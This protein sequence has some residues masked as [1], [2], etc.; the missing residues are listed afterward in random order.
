MPWL[1]AEASH[2]GKQLPPGEL[3]VTLKLF[4]VIRYTL[5]S[6]TSEAQVAQLRKHI[7]SFRAILTKLHPFLPARVTNFHIIEHIPDDIPTYEDVPPGPTRSQSTQG[8]R[9]LLEILRHHHSSVYVWGGH[10]AI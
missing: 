8:R 1:W 10:H 3:S 7:D 6:S 2:Q 4:A 9:P 5:Q